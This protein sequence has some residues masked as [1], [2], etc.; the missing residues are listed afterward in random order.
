MSISSHSFSEIYLHLNWHC[1][2]DRPLIRPE[3]EPV[4]HRF[5]LDYCKGTK[6]IHE[7]VCG[8]T[9]DHV[10]LAFRIEPI[11]TLSE[12]IGNIKGASSHAINERFGKGTLYWQR[13]FGIVSLARMNFEGI[14]NYVRDQKRHHQEGTTK[15][16][17]E[18]H[19]EGEQGDG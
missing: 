17:L 18:E 8:G 2:D 10:H 6:G 13:G 12:L 5:L 16:K 9:S 15:S 3:I 11:V 1:K 7:A 4:L 14:V 19:G